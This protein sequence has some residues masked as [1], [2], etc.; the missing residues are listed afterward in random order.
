M[1]ATSDY[2]FSKYQRA[3]LTNDEVCKELGVT[4]EGLVSLIK[5]KALSPLPGPDT[6][7]P[8]PGV[9]RYL[10]GP[11]EATTPHTPLTTPQALGLPD[12]LTVQDLMAVMQIGRS[13]AYRL[14][15]SGELQAVRVGT[16]LR[17]PKLYLKKYLDKKAQESYA[18]T[19][20]DMSGLS[21][22]RRSF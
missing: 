5:E 12:V 7:F 3:V 8:V 4:E 20:N 21:I 1:S 11:N 10:D 22:E 2:L 18:H 9:A 15:R 19:G 14:I 6:R 13:S 17:I 16:S